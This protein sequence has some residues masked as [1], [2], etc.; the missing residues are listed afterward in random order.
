MTRPRVTYGLARRDD[1]RALRALLR[2]TPMGGAI[3][4]AF[5]RE[6]SFFPAADM[7][8]PFVQVLVARCGERLVGLATRAVR[9]AYVDGE[10]RELGYL[11][12]L[13][14]HPD[15]RGTTALARGYRYLRELHADGR[16]D[17]YATVIV[18]DNRS[19]LTTIAANRAG[20]PRYTDLG[21]V[22]TP[23]MYLRRKKP[24]PDVDVVRG[25][26]ELLPAIVEK[27]N[28]N[29]LQLAPVYR[30]EDFLGGRFPSFRIEDFYLLRRG[31]G[32]AG[33]LGV[34]DQSSFRQTVVTAY[35]GWLGRLR[36]LVNLL[37]RPRLPDPGTR[38]R[39]FYLAFVATDDVAAYRSLVRF[40]YNAHTTSGYTHFTTG[41]HE[42]DPRCRVFDEYGA[43]PFA[44]RL[45]TVTFDGPPRLDGR[46]P[47]VEAA[48]L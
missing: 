32:L 37:R 15:F 28:E 33:V 14:L 42:D 38:L 8:G 26:R 18:A 10:R 19:V 20:L 22:L 1:D 25:S 2:D 40:V 41:L 45:F 12:D 46:V 35:H 16:T 44:G 48:L 30:E 4:V 24:A 9:P 47:W 27:L 43:T 23:V 17:L 36:F 11:G 6:P 21:R 39:F 7:Q 34:W 29:R 5:L 31:G 3:E 13:R